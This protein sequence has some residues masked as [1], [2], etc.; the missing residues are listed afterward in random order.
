MSTLQNRLAGVSVWMPVAGVCG[1][2]SL[3][4]PVASQS[5]RRLNPHRLKQFTA[6]YG[7]IV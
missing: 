6:H 4:T 2:R 7:A 5:C 1:G 3:S